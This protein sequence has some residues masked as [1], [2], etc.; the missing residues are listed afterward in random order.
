[1]CV[2]V[3]VC[4]LD[5]PGRLYQWEVHILLLYIHLCRCKSCTS[6]GWDPIVQLR[7]K[8]HRTPC[9]FCCL[10][11]ASAH[12]PARHPCL[13]PRRKLPLSITLQLPCP[14]VEHVSVQIVPIDVIP[15]Q[16]QRKGHT[17]HQREACS[18][19][20]QGSAQVFRNVSNNQQCLAAE[21]HAVPDPTLRGT[22]LSTQEMHMFLQS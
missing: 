21:V 8:A 1:V 10:A 14:V 15:H 12:T 19:S 11:V 7:H 5:T 22:L 2:C 9:T 3:C 4:C 20:E 18:A 6:R 16:Q 13:Y 17:K